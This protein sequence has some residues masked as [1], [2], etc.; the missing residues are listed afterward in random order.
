MLPVAV[1]QSSSDDSTICY[2]LQFVDDVM[3]LYN[4]TSGPESKTTC[5]FHRVRQVAAPVGRQSVLC[6]VEFARSKAT[7]YNCGLF[8]AVLV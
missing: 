7:I 3:F 6:L 1:A 2:V 4:G 5:I 8:S